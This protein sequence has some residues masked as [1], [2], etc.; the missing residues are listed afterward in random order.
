MEA[1]MTTSTTLTPLIS[2]TCSLETR[3]EPLDSECSRTGASLLVHLKLGSDYR[4]I[5]DHGIYRRGANR[6]VYEYMTGFLVEKWGKGPRQR[7]W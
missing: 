7:G 2:W 6:E 5:S 3:F 1:Q 4:V